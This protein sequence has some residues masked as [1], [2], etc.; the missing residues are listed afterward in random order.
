M[1]RDGDG[2]GCWDES[3]FRYLLAIEAER[4]RRAATPLCVVVVDAGGAVTASNGRTRRPGVEAA[5][6]APALARCLRESDLV[7]WHR[8][9]RRA[10]ALLTETDA[11][12]ETAHLVGAKVERALGARLPAELARR[13][14][15]RVYRLDAPGARARFHRLFAA[16]ATAE[17]VGSGERRGAAVTAS[18]PPRIAKAAAASRRAPA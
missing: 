2:M 10:A 1:V 16:P 12:P 14:R 5:G 11:G 13:L 15:V 17:T 7:G 6:L 4:A 3:A 8:A 18:L 9:N